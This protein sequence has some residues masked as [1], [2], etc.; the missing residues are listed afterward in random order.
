MELVLI[1]LA[2][3]LLV[4]LPVSFFMLMIWGF[5]YSIYKAL[6]GGSKKGARPADQS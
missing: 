2:V 5:F 1:L 4:V 3:I 6:Q